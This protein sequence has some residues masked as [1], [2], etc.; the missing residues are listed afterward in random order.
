MPVAASTGALFEYWTT[1]LVCLY[2]FS[3]VY[4]SPLKPLNVCVQVP[5]IGGNVDGSARFE[6]ASGLRTVNVV[7]GGWLLCSVYSW[8]PVQ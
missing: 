7:S 8:S 3:A 6:L 5:P 2:W 1:S 4:R